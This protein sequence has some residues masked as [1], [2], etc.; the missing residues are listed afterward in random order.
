MPFKDVNI[1]IQSKLTIEAY[2]KISNEPDCIN[3]EL[4]KLDDS[5]QTSGPQL[6]SAV[7]KLTNE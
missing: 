3:D 1:N 4:H 7:C 6:E 5:T 2:S